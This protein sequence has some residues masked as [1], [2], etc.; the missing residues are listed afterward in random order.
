M[1]E[2]AVARI[3]MTAD[4]TEKVESEGISTLKIARSGLDRCGLSEEVTT[5]Q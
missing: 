3:H 4:S 5:V 1:F 2:R